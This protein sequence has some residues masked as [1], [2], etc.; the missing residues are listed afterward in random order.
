MRSFDDQSAVLV[1]PPSASSRSVGEKRTFTAVTM[2]DDNAQIAA[3]H[4]GR[5][6]LHN[7]RKWS[8]EKCCPWTSISLSMIIPGRCLEFGNEYRGMAAKPRPQSI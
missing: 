4:A 7:H 6:R 5:N 3:V 1:K 2:D 8:V